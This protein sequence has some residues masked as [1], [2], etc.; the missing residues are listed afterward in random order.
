M[1]RDTPKYFL[2]RVLGVTQQSLMFLLMTSAISFQSGIDLRF[3]CVGCFGSTWLV[4]I[5]L[6]YFYFA[7]LG[8]FTSIFHPLFILVTLFLRH[9]SIRVNKSFTKDTIK[10]I[11]R[12]SI[13]EHHHNQH[14]S[15]GSS[16]PRGSIFASLHRSSTN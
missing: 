13:T 11:V 3:F 6:S 5:C 1:I 12:I 16:V 4:V 9:A 15:F 10:S 14:H 8:V 2:L 7:S